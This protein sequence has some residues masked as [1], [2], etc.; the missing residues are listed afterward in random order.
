MSII[1]IS[2][3]TKD[4]GH[5]RGVFDLCFS[6]EKGEVFGFL[7]PNG[8]GKTTTIR[9]LLGF[10]RPDSG[11]VSILGM[12]CFRD[13][14]DPE[15]PW[16][17]AGGDCFYRPYDRHGIFTFFGRDEGTLGSFQGP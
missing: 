15:T 3:I 10:I 7:G 9:Q 11:F 6:V 17:P 16:I 13:A 5:G 8:A 2:Q 4:F 12:D 14:A 1:E